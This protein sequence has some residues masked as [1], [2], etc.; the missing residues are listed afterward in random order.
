VLGPYTLLRKLA[1]GGMAEVYLARPL[2]AP[3]DSQ[4]VVVK[5]MLPELASD[6]QFLAMFINE[7]QLAA[8]MRHPGIV[9]VLDFGEA[10]GRIF[11]AMEYVA[12]L[13][14]WRFS[15]RLTPWGEDHAAVA[16]FIV[17]QVLEA[18][19]Y[20]HGV[21]DV[22]GVPLCV[23]HRDLSPSNIYL[24]VDGDVR[25][26][27]F[28]IARIDSKRYRKVTMIPK[29]KC[30]YVAP[31]QLGGATV[32]ARAD[33]FSMGVVLA[34]LLIGKRMFAGPSQLSTL[35]DIRDGRLPTLD[36]NQ[37]LL[38][39]KM[40]SILHRA[41]ARFPGARFESA[42]AFRQTLR[43]YAQK[44]F[45]GIGKQDLGSLVRRALTLADSKVSGVGRGHN[46]VTPISQEAT[47]RNVEQG[48]L[49]SKA[50]LTPVTVAG[51]S[52]MPLDALQETPA[53][54][55]DMETP[56]SQEGTP[57]TSQDSVDVVNWTYAV[58]M[59]DGT[60]LGP[61][62]YASLVELIFLE[63]IGLDTLVSVRQGPFRP[64]S[65]YPELS[66]HMPTRTP[67]TTI[68][69]LSDPLARGD[70]AQDPPASVCLGL[71]ERAFSGA[72]V[73]R[74]GPRR[75]EVYWLEGKPVYVSSNDPSEMLGEYL[76][77]RG[78]IG[79]AELD[80]ALAL[81]P[82]FNGHLGDTL[83]ALGLLSGVELLCLIGEQIAERFSVALL[84]RQG[85]YEIY[86]KIACRV[87]VVKVELEPLQAI[88]RS[89]LEID[90]GDFEV[91]R[92]WAASATDPVRPGNGGLERLER[93]CLPREIA[94]V[95]RRLRQPEPV[96][97]I[98]GAQ[99]ELFGEE[100]V[101]R[102][103]YIGLETGIWRL[104][105]GVVPWREPCRNS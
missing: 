56:F 100:D 68:G 63:K 67:T 95:L 89:L 43:D 85:T 20:V 42:A 105:R 76:L 50:S 78:A 18:L 54:P 97:S 23:V 80:T 6:P 9:R 96:S 28:G 2:D 91:A 66:R 15:R 39:P 52:K 94:I 84:W 74:R 70:F 4:P 71:A 31:E 60:T 46:D 29:G 99:S 32:D 93:L 73:A 65:A 55:D 51:E 44:A 17:M 82:K 3:V 30:G 104:E 45:S 83:I 57:V 21:T 81:L 59:P 53:F 40:L 10:S 33:I 13:D 41:L 11:M 24:S 19:E 5:C 88:A 90:K 102:A 25:L 77:A 98:F 16:V 72:L 49:T 35:M 92:A 34:E 37:H 69:D 12:G 47:D 64:A 22:N 26:G 61:T 27:D 8:Q 36:R 48:R 14:C 7:A 58:R 101:A 75:K 79:K 86:E 103:I 38:E 87:D 62:S 1:H